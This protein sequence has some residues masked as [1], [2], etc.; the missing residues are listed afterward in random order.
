MK[1]LA[2]SIVH[3]MKNLKRWFDENK[4]SLNLEKTKF[5]IFGN[6]EK[7]DEVVLTIVV[8]IVDIERVSEFR[9]LGGIV[10]EKL[11]WKSHIAHV[12]KRCQ[13]AFLF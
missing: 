10:D 1:E 11:T 8:D 7:D 9:F 3:E 5:M 13:R 6:R 4:L 2:D 12:K